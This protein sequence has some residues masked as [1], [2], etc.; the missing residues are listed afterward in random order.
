VVG[1]RVRVAGRLPV[2]VSE[3]GGQDTGRAIQVHRPSRRSEGLRERLVDNSAN[4]GCGD[5]GC[6]SRDRTEERGVWQVLVLELTTG[7]RFHGVGEHHERHPVQVRVRDAVRHR[8]HTR[9]QRREA[10]A[11]RAGDLRLRSRHQRAARF[12][13]GED[14]GE[15]V[16]ARGLDDIQV[17]SAAGHAEDGARAGARQPPHDVLGDFHDEVNIAS[18]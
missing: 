16:N 3:D 5:V 15:A 10:H 11:R 6:E 12:G 2:C 18:S 14:E 4:S 9:A 1:L 7:S 8:G 17:A 13:V